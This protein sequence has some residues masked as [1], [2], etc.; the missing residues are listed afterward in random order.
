[1]S[2]LIFAAARLRLRAKSFQNDKQAL[3][4]EV[5]KITDKYKIKRA[6]TGAP[7]PMEFRKEA[8]PPYLKQ[9]QTDLEKLG[10]RFERLPI[11]TPD[12][13]AVRSDGRYA[14]TDYLLDIVFR[15]DELTVELYY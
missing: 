2:K 5:E 9:L 14:S 12:T 10:F 6:N 4:H 3:I 15:H 1:M 11:H 7:Y 13:L 8:P